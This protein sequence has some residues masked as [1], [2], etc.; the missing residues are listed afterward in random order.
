MQDLFF[1]LKSCALILEFSFYDLFE[2]TLGIIAAAMELHSANEPCDGRPTDRCVG[3]F[4]Q[5]ISRIQLT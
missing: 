5:K 1:E 4:D 3:T 2:G